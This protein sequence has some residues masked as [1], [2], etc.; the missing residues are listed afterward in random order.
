[1][2]HLAQVDSKLASAAPVTGIA[3]ERFVGRLGSRVVSP[4]SALCPAH[5]DSRP[6]LS[7]RQ[8]DTGVI[9]TCQAGCSITDV[10]GALGLNLSDLFDSPIK[11]DSRDIEYPYL[12]EHGQLL[13]TVVRTPEKRFYQRPA[14]GKTGIGAMEGVR[15]VPYRLPDLLAAVALGKTIYVPEG[16][17]DV[18]A[19]GAAG[20]IATCNSGGAGKWRPEFA[21]YFV[22]ASVV[23]VADRDPAGER[24]AEQVR[25]SLTSAA[26]SVRVV[27]AA[28]GKDASD[29]LAAGRSVSEFVDWSPATAFGRRTVSLTS[30]ANVRTR[31]AH[32]AWEP[33]PG[34]PLI[35]IGE[36]TL[37]QGFEGTGK[38]VLLIA[39]AAAITRGTLPG[40]LSGTPRAIIIV[41][42]EDSH[43]HTIVPRLRAAGA[44][45]RLVYFP[46]VT[47]AKGIADFLTLPADVGVL[48]DQMR[49]TNAALVILDPLDSRLGKLDTHKDAEVRRALEPLVGLANSTDAAIVGVMHYNK[50]NAGDR[51]NRTMGSRAFSA[52]ARAILDVTVDPADPGTR[53]VILSKANLGPTGLPALRF[54]LEADQVGVD[55]DGTPII[56]ARIVWDGEDTRSVEALLAL[57]T[58]S[59]DVRSILDDA[60]D[61]MRGALQDGVEHPSKEI[62]QMGEQAGYS[63]AS[64][65]RARERLAVHVRAAGMPRETFWTLPL[66]D[67]KEDD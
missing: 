41:A 49:S 37:V 67:I 15:R 10:V 60:T 17:K 36:L 7:F 51:R 3:L 23:I 61:W 64:I 11:A 39:L 53:L 35:P 43:E 42:T 65:T 48:E 24:H 50:M 13:Y 45:L 2:T 16:E 28:T 32:W 8:G 19:L 46:N 20:C 31:A 27:Q 56:A 4:G 9:L 34:L 38:S 47:D 6:S 59:S 21:Q 62:K 44:D 18:D 5:D 52:V 26:Q 40:E 66:S 55:D 54:Q 33:R 30:A 57:K 29:H 14:S 25:E 1:M 22:G 63:S 12:D 58:S